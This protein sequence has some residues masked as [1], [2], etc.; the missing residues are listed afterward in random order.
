MDPGTAPGVASFGIQVLQGIVGYYQKYKNYRSDINDFCKSS[1][2]LL[3]TLELLRPNIQSP[4]ASDAARKN[5]VSSIDQC[6]DAINELKATIEKI[7]GEDT[8][9]HPTMLQKLRIRGKD[10]GR[11][12]ACPL[13]TSTLDAMNQ[14]VQEVRDN[15]ALALQSLRRNFYPTSTLRSCVY[16]MVSGA[17]HA[18]HPK[19]MDKPNTNRS[20]GS[21][22]SKMA[23]AYQL[24]W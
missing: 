14:C 3:R 4:S 21:G 17:H 24:C 8:P 10:Q 12:M 16:V 5:V 1:D 18:D 11:R 9:P 20:R 19:R 2:A 15:L 22:G 13:R 7:K 6:E 23:S